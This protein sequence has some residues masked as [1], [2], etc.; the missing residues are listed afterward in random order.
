MQTIN[1]KYVAKHSK[2]FVFNGRISYYMLIL[3]QFDIYE[4]KVLNVLAT[5]LKC[6]FLKCKRYVSYLP[7]GNFIFMLNIILSSRLLILFLLSLFLIPG[8]L[9]DKH[10]PKVGR[11]YAILN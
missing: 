11:L 2:K 10:L 6:L 9:F 4:E 3:V 1:V 7:L 8:L 5:I